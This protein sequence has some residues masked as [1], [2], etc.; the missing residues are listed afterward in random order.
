MAYAS[1]PTVDELAALEQAFRQDAASS[2]VGLARCLVQLGRPEDAIQVCARGL[3][4]NPNSLDGRLSLGAALVALHRWKEAQ[5]E[6]LEVV[7]ADRNNS[8]GFRLLGE[9]LM[10]QDDYE[11]ALPVLQHA[12][13]LNPSDSELPGLVCRARDGHPLDPP[14]PIPTPLQPVGCY[15][16]PAPAARPAVPQAAHLP[17]P[18]SPLLPAAQ[19]PLARV[20][21][22]QE[23]VQQSAPP[24]PTDWVAASVS[25]DRR[26]A[27][28]REFAPIEHHQAPPAENPHAPMPRAGPA[29]SQPPQQEPWVARRSAPPAAP[30]APATPSVRPRVIPAAKPKDAAQEGLRVSAAAGEQYLNRLLQGGLLDVPNVR[31]KEASY[32]V[33]PGKRWGRSASRISMYLFV[34][35][36]AAG[37]GSGVWYWYEQKQVDSDIARYLENAKALVD[38]G[39]R[40]DLAK[41]GEE[42]KKALERDTTDVYTMA[43]LAEVTS[44]STLLYG[45]YT[46]GEEQQAISL[47][48]QKISEPGQTG[49][50]E[51]VI[52]RSANALAELSEL[53]EGADGRLATAR[54]ELKAWLDRSPDDR[55]ARWLLGRALLAGGNRTA[56]KTAFFQA[57]S[58]G[59]GPTI[60]TV[61]LA[62]FHLDE[63]E[64]GMAMKLY[65]DALGRSQSHALAF[66]GRSL[67]RSERRLEAQ[68]AMADIS[69]G[70]AQARGMK[71][72]AWKELSLAGASQSLGNYEAFG[73]ALNRA[74]AE[75]GPQEPRFLARLGL[76]RVSQGRIVDAAGIRGAIRWFAA[77]PESNPLVTLLD[78]ELLLARG[79]P[80]AALEALEGVKGVRA[81]VARGRALFDAGQVSDALLSFEEALEVSPEDME[82][83]A[84]AEAARMVSSSGSVRRKADE[85]LDSL[86]RK[87]TTKTA[88]FVH[89]MALAAVGKNSLAKDKLQKS[90]EDISE[91]FPNPLAYRSFLSLGRIAYAKG[92]M[93]AALTALRASAEANPG[94]LPTRDMLGQVL[95]E[96]D[97]QEALVN[98]ADVFDAGVATVGSELALAR[99]LVKTGGSKEDA[100]SAIRRAKERGASAAAL[101][102]A[103]ADVDE[104]LYVELEVTPPT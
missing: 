47:V 78:V 5:A 88:R 30:S 7:K 68:E 37:S 93:S 45:E 14:A 95:V 103:I 90:V 23:A 20:E 27:N 6:L 12:Q 82:L 19:P 26:A 43:V 81:S 70:L 86:G 52:A 61:D 2:F 94:Y 31:V 32:D 3:Q 67:A 50:R 85:A 42:A 89:G 4:A 104:E 62:N 25:G 55:L 87:A 51:L 63:G 28:E 48:A 36:L 34:V 18:A 73:A 96:S 41:A 64:F 57:H 69:I 98:F 29:P 66:V 13:N 100:R 79:L 54:Q 80:V 39:D 58:S 35:L 56:A 97:A 92:N 46:P 71:L 53:T 77:D 75:K 17:P 22:A 24:M 60:A 59:E 84:W 99:A 74:G 102:K 11:R 16:A 49:Y 15:S 44:L 38:S 101:R 40:G 9:V 72:V 21:L 65:D 76:A 10:R 8:A 91:A 1:L 83:R 33:A